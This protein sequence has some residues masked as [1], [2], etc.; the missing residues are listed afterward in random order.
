MH[1]INN[2][3]PTKG[4]AHVDG[5]PGDATKVTAL[6][7]LVPPLAAIQA[8]VFFRETLAPLQIVGFALALGGVLLTRSARLRVQGGLRRNLTGGTIRLGT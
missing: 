5:A 8:F 3:Q 4:T 6:L 2:S 1:D 7:L